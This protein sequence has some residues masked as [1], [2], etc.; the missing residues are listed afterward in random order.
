MGEC[1]AWKLSNF[2]LIS[3]SLFP[4][5]HSH[6]LQCDIDSLEGEQTFL[7]TQLPRLGS[8]IVFAHNDLLL[9][10]I[11]FNAHQDQVTFIDFEY[12]DY[13]YQAF[14][15]A[16]HFCEFCGVDQFDAQLYPDQ[17]FQLFW[18]RAYL[19]KWK[20]LNTAV[21]GDSV[22]SNGGVHPHDDEDEEL[23]RLHEVVNKFS[24]A[25]HFYW[26][27]WALVQSENSSINFD[28]VHYAQVRLGEYFKRKW[29]LFGDQNGTNGSS[30]GVQ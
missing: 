9:K 20:E 2:S 29:T 5:S 14:D 26:G 30:N 1:F 15:I 7:A 11:I 27:L 13:N 12:S 6:H 22:A 24:L 17:E 4:L 19:A 3:V 23:A 10:N 25:A 8:P 21:N 28:Y 18:L 16:N